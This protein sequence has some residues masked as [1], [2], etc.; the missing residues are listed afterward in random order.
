MRE[1]ETVFLLCNSCVKNIMTIFII[2]RN[3]LIFK[4]ATISDDL[5]LF[6]REKGILGRK[7]LHQ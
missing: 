2:A 3:S 1:S 4:E 7:L 5:S 6:L